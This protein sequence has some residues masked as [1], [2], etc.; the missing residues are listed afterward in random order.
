M[1]SRIQTHTHTHTYKRQHT[2]PFQCYLCALPFLFCFSFHLLCSAIVT[3]SHNG[4]DILLYYFVL[5]CFVFFYFLLSFMLFAHS[6]VANQLYTDREKTV[7]D[8]TEWKRNTQLNTRLVYVVYEHNRISTTDAQLHRIDFP[9]LT[10]RCVFHISLSLC[11]CVFAW[12][13]I[14]CAYVEYTR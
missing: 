9:Q 11:V 14:E 5:F 8:A 2:T 4:F 7:C 3:H 6:K 10:V 13:C 1:L 12:E